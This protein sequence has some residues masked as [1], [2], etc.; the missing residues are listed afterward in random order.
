[1]MQDLAQMTTTEL[2]R[3]ISEYRNDTEAFRAALGVMISRSD[4]ANRHP[5]LSSMADPEATFAALLKEHLDRS[6]Q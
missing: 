1:M 3:F 2:K 6:G 5:P 4:G